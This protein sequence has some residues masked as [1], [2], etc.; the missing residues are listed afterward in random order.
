MRHFKMK[1]KA[2]LDFFPKTPDT[3]AAFFD[4]LVMEQ[5][6][7]TRGQ[8]G[9]PRLKIVFD[10]FIGVQSVDVQEIDTLIFNASSK[11]FLSKVEK[12]L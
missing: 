11:V 3:K 5:D 6:H 10:R 2:G 12:A 9:Q 8:L 7:G 4:R 1:G